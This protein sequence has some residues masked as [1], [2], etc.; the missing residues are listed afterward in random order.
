MY[1]VLDMWNNLWKIY[2]IKNVSSLT[3][4][5][6]VDKPLVRDNSMPG[7]LSHQVSTS[8]FRGWSIEHQEWLAQN[9]CRK[10][11]AYKVCMLL[12]KHL[13]T[14]SSLEHHEMQKAT[15]QTQDFLWI[16][17][18]EWSRKG[19][20]WAQIQLCPLASLLWAESFTKTIGRTRSRDHGRGTWQAQSRDS[21]RLRFYGLIDFKRNVWSLN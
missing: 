6:M 15:L 1:T 9:P 14:V 11:A 17:H 8:S 18:L 10:G 2:F 5:R 12:S 7:T 13:H 16:S 19:Q 21:R 4:T 20:R 3:A